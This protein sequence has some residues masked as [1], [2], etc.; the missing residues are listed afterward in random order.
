MITFIKKSLLYPGNDEVL[1]RAVYALGVLRGLIKTNF[2]DKYVYTKIYYLCQSKTL[3]I[4]LI[5]RGRTTVPRALHV[6]L[7]FKN[8]LNTTYKY[9]GNKVGRSTYLWGE[10]K[11]G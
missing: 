2:T 1:I 3:L 9:T 6:N 8:V 5:P 10:S 4:K 7:K 11:K